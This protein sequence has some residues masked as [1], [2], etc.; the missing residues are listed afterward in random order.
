LFE[1]QA[2]RPTSL[3]RRVLIAVLAVV[4]VGVVMFFILRPVKPV[5]VNLIPEP[6]RCQEGQTTGCVGGKAMVIS[7]PAPAQAPAL[8]PSGAAR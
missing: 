3:R 2:F 5:P 8:A 1:V 6:R 4:A 7:A